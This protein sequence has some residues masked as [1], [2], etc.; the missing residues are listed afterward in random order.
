MC[1]VNYICPYFNS[2]TTESTQSNNPHQTQVPIAH[3]PH[4]VPPTLNPLVNSPPVIPPQQFFNPQPP[5]IPSTIP[6]STATYSYPSPIFHKKTLCIHLKPAGYHVLPHPNVHLNLVAFSSVDLNL[7]RFPQ[8]NSTPPPPPKANEVTNNAA[9]F[10]NLQPTL[11]SSTANPASGPAMPQWT[12]P[13]KVYS[14]HEATCSNHVKQF[15]TATNID[16]PF[17][18]PI[19]PPIYGHTATAPLRWGGAL[20]PTHPTPAA[21]N[22]KPYYGVG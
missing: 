8:S 7:W 3:S 18:T 2:T 4:K 11:P 17:V 13:Q 20:Q 21:E 12:A 1:L 22:A 10:H 5:V 19:I 9:V 14:N 6:A 15:S 16:P